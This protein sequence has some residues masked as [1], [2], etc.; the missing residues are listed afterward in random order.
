MNTPKNSA[1]IRNKRRWWT[2]GTIVAIADLIL[3]VILTIVL[4]LFGQAL[5]VAVV[6]TSNAQTIGTAAWIGLSLLISLFTAIVLDVVVA[7]F[8]AFGL[9]LRWLMKPQSQTYDNRGYM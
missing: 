7:G 4:S 8:I 2:I 5:I 6:H 9:V 1:A 3:V